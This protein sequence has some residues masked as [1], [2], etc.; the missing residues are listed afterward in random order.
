LQFD[1]AACYGEAFLIIFVSLI[2]STGLPI[3]LFFASIG[4][5][6]KVSVPP[7]PPQPP[8]VP[9]P[10]SLLLCCLP[11]AGA[12]A[13]VQTAGRAIADSPPLPS[14]TLTSTPS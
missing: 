3:L 6:Y 11:A 8:P 7:P 1:L 2:Y 12:A 9:C 13:G 4:F 14:T 10:P 5:T